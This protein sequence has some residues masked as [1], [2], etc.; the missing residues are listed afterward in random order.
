MDHVSSIVEPQ[1]KLVWFNL[2]ENQGTFMS[3]LLAKE[4][5]PLNIASTEQSFV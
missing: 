3:A 1:R 5:Q 2:Q 4:I